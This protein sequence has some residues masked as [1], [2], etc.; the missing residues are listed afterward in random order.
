MYDIKLFWILKIETEFY[1]LDSS[2]QLVNTYVLLSYIL[3]FQ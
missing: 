1:R 3:L 2:V